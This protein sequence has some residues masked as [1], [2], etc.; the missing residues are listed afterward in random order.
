MKQITNFVKKLGLGK[1]LSVLFAGLLL[2]T[3]TACNPGTETGARPQNPPVQAGGMNN[4]H[5]A[6]GDGYT[7][8]RM[9]N[10]IRVNTQ[11]KSA[12]ERAQRSSDNSLASNLGSSSS[13]QLLYPGSE[14]SET[15]KYPQDLGGDR[16]LLKV[17]GQ[18]QATAQPVFNRNDGDAKLLE[19]A[20]AVFKDA[21]QFIK[22]GV[23][24]ES[25]NPAKQPPVNENMNLNNTAR[26]KQ[27]MSPAK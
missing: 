14:R 7:N 26:A 6:G 12:K 24:T 25:Y 17:P 16:S 2:F 10:D 3:T 11:G 20:G 19:R 8:E 13:Q 1:L 27:G 9:S 15:D 21:S 5:K 23:E 18:S 4:P 22:D